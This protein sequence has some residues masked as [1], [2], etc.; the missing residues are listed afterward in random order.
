[1]TRRDSPGKVP[2]SD[3]AAFVLSGSPDEYRT[4]IVELVSLTSV[5]P[6]PSL[7]PGSDRGDYRSAI[8]ELIQVDGLEGAETDLE[9][10]LRDL[11]RR[12]RLFA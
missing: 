4:V 10:A 8:A 5:K 11:G 1:M 7:A 6:A 2:D 9:L 12:P 3:L